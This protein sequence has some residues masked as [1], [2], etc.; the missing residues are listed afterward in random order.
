MGFAWSVQAKIGIVYINQISTGEN[1]ANSK[2]ALNTVLKLLQSVV[3]LETFS[4]GNGSFILD[5]VA[6]KTIVA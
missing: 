1:I 6:T 5:F 3:V 4:N 2:Y